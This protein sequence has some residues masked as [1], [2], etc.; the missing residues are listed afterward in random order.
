MY[1]TLYLPQGSLTTPDYSECVVWIVLTQPVGV[2]PQCL[3][4][5]RELRYGGQGT[6]RMGT[7]ART[8]VS[9]GD[10]KVYR[11]GKGERDSEN[12]LGLTNQPTKD[13]AD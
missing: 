9:L 3:A 5:M 12:Q 13:I 10:R 7:N 4:R 11:P 1:L 6:P 8:V 2:S